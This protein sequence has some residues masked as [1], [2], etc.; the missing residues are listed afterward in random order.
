ML[1]VMQKKDK[2]EDLYFIKASCKEEA[3]RL[4]GLNDDDTAMWMLSDFDLEC[5]KSNSQMLLVL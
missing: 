4:A 1:Y 3:S 2:T 5:L